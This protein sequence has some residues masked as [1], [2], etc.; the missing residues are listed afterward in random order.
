[1]LIEVTCDEGKPR[2]LMSQAAHSNSTT[3]FADFSKREILL[4]CVRQPLD[5][6]FFTET[7]CLLKE[8]NN[9][10]F[11]ILRSED[12]LQRRFS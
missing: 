8:M 11:W 12:D 2:R 6:S 1:M 7:L 5:T 3:F 10:N 9:R 4:G